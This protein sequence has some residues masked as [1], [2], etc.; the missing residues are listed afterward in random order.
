MEH[1]IHVL[2]FSVIMISEYPIF[3]IFHCVTS[4]MSSLTAIFG[5][6]IIIYAFWKA[7]SMPLAS[8]ILL[9]SLAVSDLGVGLIV[10]PINT[11]IMVRMLVFMNSYGDEDNYAL[12]LIC[13]LVKTWQFFAVFFAGASLLTIGAISIDLYLALSLH[14]RYQELVTSARVFIVVTAIWITAF[15][16]AL[17]QTLLAFNDFINSSGEILII[18][19]ASFAYIKIY[20]IARHHHNQIQDQAQLQNQNNQMTHLASAKKLAINTLYIYVILLICYLPSLCISPMFM[21]SSTPSPLLT[22]CYFMG[23]SLIFY[24]SSLNPLVYCWK[25]R[26][27]REA[28]VD[29]LK[30][31]YS[32]CIPCNHS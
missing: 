28:V 12:H 32:R 19:L 15:L 13:P 4:L 8:R 26:E 18:I 9:L 14:L 3:G 25:I 20:K 17:L 22:L 23:A 21:M 1:C 16:A 5:N 2:K 6:S 30:R 10:Q 29:I 31:L 27:V 7:S 11:A 24:N